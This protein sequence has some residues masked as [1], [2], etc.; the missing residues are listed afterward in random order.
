MELEQ[1]KGNMKRITVRILALCLRCLLLLLV[2]VLLFSVFKLLVYLVSKESQ[3]E[4]S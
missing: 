2:V 1:K 3:C 4:A